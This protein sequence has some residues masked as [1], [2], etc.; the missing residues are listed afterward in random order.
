[1]AAAAAAAVSRATFIV[2][3]PSA[4]LDVRRNENGDIEHLC[5]TPSFG[6]VDVMFSRSNIYTQVD[7]CVNRAV[8]RIFGIRAGEN[9]ACL[10]DSL[11]LPSLKGMV[12]GRRMKFLDKLLVCDGG[13]VIVQ[14]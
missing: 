7:N 10:R 3:S 12:E 8:Y 1:M 5:I 2:T 11:G 6:G 4:A 14:T 13:T 9:M